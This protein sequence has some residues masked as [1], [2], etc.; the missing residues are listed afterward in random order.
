MNVESRLKAEGFK[1]RVLQVCRTWEEWVVYPRDFLLK[2][3]NTF[4]GQPTGDSPGEADG[5]PLSGDEKDDE[6][7]DGVP[8]DG[9]ALLKSAML[10]GLPDMVA[11]ESGVR[12]S[13][14]DLN[15][16]DSDVDDDIDGIPLDEDIDGI[17]MGNAFGKAGAGGAFVPSKWETVDPEQIEAQAITTSKWDK[18]NPVT[19]DPPRIGGDSDDSNDDE[20]SLG[21]SETTRD[22]DEERRTRLREIELKILQYQDELESGKRSLKTGWTISQ[23]LEHFR[24][25]LMKKVS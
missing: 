13:T 2:L 7:L 17:P 22:Y 11:S 20:M 19:P 6:D 12:S 8:L 25:K 5:A 24:R 1:V 15:S 9:A 4:L 16:H 3:R 14:L 10:R 21:A 18:L 23:Q